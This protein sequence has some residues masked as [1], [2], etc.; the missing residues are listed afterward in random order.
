TVVPG[1]LGM[2]KVTDPTAEI[3]RLRQ[4]VAALESR[5]AVAQGAAVNLEPVNQ[6]I[7]AIEAEA[8]KRVADAEKRQ[9]DRISTLE[10][11]VRA[12]AARPATPGQP[13]PP[14]VD[15]TPLTARLQ[16]I[17]EGLKAV[18]GKAEAAAKAAEPQIAALASNVQDATRK[19]EAV[20]PALAAL[21]AKIE[22]ATQ[23]VDA[24]AAGPLFAATQGL[25]QAFNRGQSFT[26]EIAAVE[27][28]GG[29]AT[30]LAALKPFAEKGAPTP[31]ALAKAFAPL[32]HA[33]ATAGIPPEEG[34]MGFVKRF[35][36]I[37]PTGDAG[38]DSQ[39]SL[40]ATVEAALAKG[41]PT[42]ALAAWRRL[43]E[44][45]RKASATWAASAE[46]REKAAAALKQLQ[47]GVLAKL[48]TAKP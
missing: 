27:A 7:A 15:L 26:V 36:K 11:A 1:L 43:P 40:V 3:T 32:A 47:D 16:S 6:R 2:G 48:R 9:A 46:A 33:T 35:I 39:P 21:S 13:A 23:K 18:D 44:E 31:D 38:G 29:D 24:G 5:P 20:T 45:A 10:V 19:A 22:Q 25:V 4:Q 37:R 30:L 41:Q 14:P 42:D 12:A 34:A 8:Q 17:E 28:L